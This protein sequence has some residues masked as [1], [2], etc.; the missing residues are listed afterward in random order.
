MYLYRK[1]E[2]YSPIFQ[3]GYVNYVPMVYRFLDQNEKD[4]ASA[5]NKIN[6]YILENDLYEL[7]DVTHPLSALE[8]EY[9]SMTNYYLNQIKMHGTEKVIK[10]VLNH[11]YSFE[12]FNFTT[13]F[14]LAISLINGE[15]IEITQSLSV[16]YVFC[17]KVNIPSIGINHYDKDI[18]NDFPF[19][20]LKK[21][22][23]F[24]DHHLS[25]LQNI[26]D[27]NTYINYL[28]NFEK[29]PDSSILKDIISG[30]YGLLNLKD[31]FYDFEQVR[32]NYILH[33][34]IAITRDEKVEYGVI[35]KEFKSIIFEY[36]KIKL[37]DDYGIPLKI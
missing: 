37:N 10:E 33:A 16:I 29:R 26:D 9:V 13:L 24:I 34:L 23:E 14:R 2:A 19:E 28:V 12:V 32:I 31:Y 27:E 35:Q 20:T 7:S 15:I 6:E 3:G 5:K 21:P 17:N 22:K 8:R 11:D 4:S 30:Y 25:E 18:L 36:V 1:Y